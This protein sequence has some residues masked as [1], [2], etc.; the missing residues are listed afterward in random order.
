M[1]GLT[2]LQHVLDPETALQKLQFLVQNVFSHAHR[3]TAII[4]FGA[5]LSLVL[6]RAFKGLFKN[7]W[8]IY[9]LPEILIVVVVSTSKHIIYFRSVP[10]TTELKYYLPATVG[11]CRALISLDPYPSIPGHLWSISQS[12]AR[13]SNTYVKP[14]RR[15]CRFHDPF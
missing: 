3:M 14:L 4:S 8:W 11:T 12:L 7:K 15:Q 2:A 1:F 13:T 6:F 10:L 9:N 5:L